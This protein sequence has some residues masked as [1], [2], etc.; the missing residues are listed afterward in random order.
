MARS[1]MLIDDTII[2]KPIIVNETEFSGS[3]Q[4]VMMAKEDVN[5]ASL[6]SKERKLLQLVKQR[7]FP[8]N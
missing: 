1:S 6:K 2:T 4:N 3:I 5:V 8:F 7:E